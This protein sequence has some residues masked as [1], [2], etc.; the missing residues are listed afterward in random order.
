MDELQ[1]SALPYLTQSQKSVLKRGGLQTA[2]DVVL[3]PP[4]ELARQCK[5]SPLDAK[6]LINTVCENNSPQL[7]SLAVVSDQDLVCSTGDNYLDAALGGGL[8]T[9]LVWE[10][11]GQ[12]SAGKTQLA[13][14]LSLLVQI[15]PHLGGLSGSACYITVSQNLPTTRLLQIAEA[16]P[17]LSQELCGLEHISTIKS[18]SISG[19]IRIL[20]DILPGLIAQKADKKPVRLVVV[21][22]LAEL[23]HSAD[24]TSTSTLVERSQNITEISALVH[25][26][27]ST[28]NIAVLVLNEVSDVFNDQVETSP[29][30]DL[31]YKHQSRWFG[32]AAETFAGQVNKEAS[33]GLV[34]ANQ[35]NVR[36][37]LSR[38]GRR[39]YLEDD[40][41]NK[42]RKVDDGLV[43]GP[44]IDPDDDSVAAPCSLDYIVTKAGISVL[45]ADEDIFSPPERTPSPVAPPMP[46]SQSQTI[47]ANQDD[48]EDWE[49]YWNTD[50]IPLEMYNN[51]E[52]DTGN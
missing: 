13:L 9:G 30:S 19:L 23:F 24:K 36:I 26:L 37:M 34:W 28:H 51:M 5:I 8:R 42:R 43:S 14:Q 47:Q 44:S 4:Q 20:T 17:L 16:H 11:F 22:A 7:Q 27:A 52:L 12:S 38:T 40:S 41:H 2:A 3:T 21:D 48:D 50:D 32:G 1:I 39:R 49:S 25:A 46:N 18:P 15:P 33:L 29:G 6:A 45:P 10:V 35:V 31:V